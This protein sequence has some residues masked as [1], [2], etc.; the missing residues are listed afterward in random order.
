V[1]R[2]QGFITVYGLAHSIREGVDPLHL[3]T[4]FCLGAM[5]LSPLE[6][7]EMA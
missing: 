4:L 2:C 5:S 3:P 6:S 1:Q 7:P